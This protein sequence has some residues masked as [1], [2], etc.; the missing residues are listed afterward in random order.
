MVESG[1]RHSISR[2][3]SVA[4]RLRE[5]CHEPFDGERGVVTV[6]AKF[7]HDKEH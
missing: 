2:P 6:D 1:S 4:L 7:L 5:P 3:A